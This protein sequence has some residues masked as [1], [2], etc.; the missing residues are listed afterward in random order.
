[1]AE[2]SVAISGA[3][4]GLPTGSFVIAPPVISSEASVS[5]VRTVA[6]ATGN[7]TINIPTGAT[8]VIITPPLAN[9]KQL[10]FKGVTG[11]TGLRIARNHPTLV[12]LETQEPTIPTSFVLNAQSPG[13]NVEVAFL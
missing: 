9:T 11:D 2:G 3:I 8:A 7:N 6:L 4:T 1:M 12:A 5:E 10:T 13:F